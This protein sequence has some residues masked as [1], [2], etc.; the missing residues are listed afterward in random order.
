MKKLSVLL[1]AALA[2]GA[3]FADDDN[4]EK[5]PGLI[6]SISKSI[7]IFQ[8][9]ITRRR[10]EADPADVIIEPRV[11]GIG[12]LEFQR[13]GDAI[14]EGDARLTEA[15]PGIRACIEACRPD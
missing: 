5:A 12:L 8:D 11:G 9:Q 6:Y 15:L 3:L 14:K 10:L 13:A 2:S 7:H 1:I 4:T